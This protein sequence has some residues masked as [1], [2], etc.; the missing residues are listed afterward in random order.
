MRNRLGS[1]EHVVVL[2]L[3]NRSFDHML[4]FLYSDKPPRDGQPFEGLT[5][6]E[7]N[8]DSNGNPVPVYKITP[9]TPNAYFLPGADPGEG[10]KATNSQLF[11]SINA[12]S[13]QPK[14]SN[15]GFV[16][17]FSYTLSWEVSE[18]P[19]EIITGV[20]A[21]WIMGCYAP[22]TLPVLSG[23][24]RGYAVCD[25]WFGSAP[26]E[27]MPNRAFAL[28]ATSQGHM[29]DA[30]HSFTC[31]SIFG[32]LSDAGMD[33]R[34][35]G[36]N[37]PPLT[38]GNFPDTQQADDSHFGLFT[39]FVDDARAGRLPPFT[40]LEP[41][42]SGSEQNDQHPVSDISAGE[43]LI[44]DV[45]YAVRSNADAW[46]KTLLV[47][48]YDEHGGC[49]DHVAPPW[50]ATPPDASVGEFG[51]DFTRF[52]PRVPTV[53][54]S[55]LIEAGTVFRLAAGRT[56]LDH[57]S[58][59]KTLQVRWP[60]IKSLTARDAAASDIGDVLTR[61]TP[62]KDDPLQGVTAP[63]APG[64]NPFPER[65][66]HLQKLHASMLSRQPAD[67]GGGYHHTMPQ[68]RT[69]TEYHRYIWSRHEAMRRQRA[70]SDSSARREDGR[71]SRR[72]GSG[73]S[74]RA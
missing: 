68:L 70:A 36:Y 64:G 25:Q 62:R 43:R 23:L 67:G 3:E 4:G 26:T 14:T 28:A 60:A 57:T 24:A 20:E 30:S 39:N 21:S 47:I 19:T 13:S 41:A 58:V 52:G 1:I 55:P 45:Y 17:D 9:D 53:L 33:W 54:V 51:F 2:M 31:P 37:A 7:S 50:N 72:K 71:H 32:R 63:S 34:I 44:R 5:G 74:G 22:E 35:Y 16:S 40:F 46:N 11:G 10:Y 69:S 56:P 61:A 38:R 12:P 6:R 42:W 59:L 15:T 73:S 18:R 48:T 65:P 29:D 66:T 8:L 49:Y 27:T